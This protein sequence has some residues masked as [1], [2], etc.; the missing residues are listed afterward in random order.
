LRG[1]RRR[2]VLLKP[3]QDT[4]LFAAIDKVIGKLRKA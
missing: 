1:G 3:F 4:A 2:S